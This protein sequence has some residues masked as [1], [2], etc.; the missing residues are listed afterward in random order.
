[1]QIGKGFA[2]FANATALG[3]GHP[4]AFVA[5]AQDVLC[6]VPGPFFDFVET[7]QPAIDTGA[8]IITFRRDA[9]RGA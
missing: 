2:N 8:T 5:Y 9:Q 3:A 4:T 6:S 1:M 7:W